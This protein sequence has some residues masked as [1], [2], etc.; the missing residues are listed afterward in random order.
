MKFINRND[1]TKNIKLWKNNKIW[2]FPTT[3]IWALNFAF[4]CLVIFVT[5]LHFIDNFSRKGIKS[6]LKFKT[7]FATEKP[8]GYFF[9]EHIQAGI[10]TF[11]WRTIWLIILIF[12]YLI[13]SINLYLFILLFC[14]MNDNVIMRLLELELI[15]KTLL[16]VLMLISEISWFIYCSSYFLLIVLLIL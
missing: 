11:L 14:I 7:F 16:I 15:W 1:Q 4:L 5:H 13:I 3:D 8:I 2:E 9:T 6:I 12:I 10:D